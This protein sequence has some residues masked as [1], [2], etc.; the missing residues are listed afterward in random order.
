MLIPAKKEDTLWCKNQFLPMPSISPF[1]HYVMETQREYKQELSPYI[2]IYLWVMIAYSLVVIIHN[3]IIG[4]KH[5]AIGIE[6][7]CVTL[8]I[9]L[10]L[11]DIVALIMILR[12]KSIGVWI[13][14]STAFFSVLLSMAYPLFMSPLVKYIN[15]LMKV[16]LLI[17]LNFK[18][19]GL[20]GY[21]SLGMSKIDGRYI[22]EWLTGH[23]RYM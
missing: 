16:G 18:Q 12:K 15:I 14:V 1:T 17:V 8:R 6:M 19:N 23:K 7:L 4:V 11:A 20:T 13:Y 3:I 10:N 22:D 9:I 2:K 21:Q 5:P